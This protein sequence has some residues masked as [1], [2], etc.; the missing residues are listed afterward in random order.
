MIFSA[1][2]PGQK[3]FQDL[4]VNSNNP[5]LFIECKLNDDNISKT[6]LKFQNQLNIPA[7]QLIDKESICRLKRNGANQ[8]LAASASR[9]LTMLP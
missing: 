5:F 6:I 8:M 7:V 3:I 9:W 4:F 2:F 1:S